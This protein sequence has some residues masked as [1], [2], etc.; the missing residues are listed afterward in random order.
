LVDVSTR[1]RQW[2]FV[3]GEGGWQ[4]RRGKAEAGFEER[5]EAALTLLRNSGPERILTA[6]EVASVDAG[7]FGLDRQRCA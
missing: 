4:M 7:Q 1:D 5:L 2:L 6:A 3:R